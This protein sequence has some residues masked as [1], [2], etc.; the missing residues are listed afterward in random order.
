MIQ[1]EPEEHHKHLQVGLGVHRKHLQQ[2]H[3]E[4]HK[5]LQRGLE[6]R[7]TILEPGE[8]HMIPELGEHCSCQQQ[9][10]RI[11]QL[12]GR[13]RYQQMEHHRCQC[14]PGDHCRYRWKEIRSHWEQEPQL[15]GLCLLPTGFQE[16][17]ERQKNILLGYRDKKRCIM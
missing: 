9:G 7:H 6:E 1:Q 10:H 3:W 4:R 16:Q 15:S 12:Q 5:S 11:Q 2:E 8:R 13:H 14:W 17:S